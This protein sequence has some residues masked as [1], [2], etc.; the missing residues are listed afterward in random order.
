MALDRDYFRHSKKVT[1][2]R[3]WQSVRHAVLERDG[4]R[5][6][7]CGAGGRLEVHHVQ[8]VRIAPHLAFD[9]ANLTA[10]C[11]ACHTR[12]TR[13]EVGHA[14]LSEDRQAWRQAVLTLEREGK[15]PNEHKGKTNA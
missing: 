5:C 15:K 6:T 12:I 10:L 3:R 8:A 4:Y 13:L 11:P 2:S 7:A 1:H 14:P 9:P